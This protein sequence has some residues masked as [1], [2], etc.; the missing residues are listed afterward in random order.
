MCW[1]VPQGYCSASLPGA[2]TGG[3]GWLGWWARKHS[4]Q[5]SNTRGT[6]HT[7][8]ACRTHHQQRKHMQDIIARLHLSYLPYATPDNHPGSRA[9]AVK[10][11]VTKECC[12]SVNCN[13]PETN[14]GFNTDRGLLALPGQCIHPIRIHICK[15]GQ[16][17]G[18]MVSASEIHLHGTTGRAIQ[19]NQG[20]AIGKCYCKAASK[21]FLTISLSKVGILRGTTQRL[22]MFTL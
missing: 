4:I 6:S 15:N 8:C 16:M 18:C 5:E 13:L 21:T 1:G 9:K 2:A 11:G 14:T 19:L 12:K 22:H 20:H 3:H 7:P 10:W 17:W